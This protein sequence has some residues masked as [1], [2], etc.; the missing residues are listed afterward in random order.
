MELTEFKNRIKSGNSCG[1][2]IFAGEEDYLKKYYLSL[3]REQII[4]DDAFAFFNHTVFEGDD[5]DFASVK[6][7]IK[8]PPMMSEYKLIEWRFADIDS[9]KESEKGALEELFS[10]KEDYPNVCFAILATSAGFDTGTPKRPSKTAARLGSG[11][12]IITL[13]KSTEP[14]LLAWLKRHFEAE[15]IYAPMQALN[16]L[17]FRSG[18]SMDTLNNEV[19]KLCCYAKSQGKSEISVH[20]VEEISASSPESDAFALSNAVIEKNISKAFLAMSDLKMRRV[21]PNAIIA[22]LS[23]TYSELVSVSLLFS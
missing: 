2:Y 20:N 23:R 12:D 19:I 15:G 16:A 3:L 8:S 7:A 17:I 11:F 10:V 18:R 5:I 6:E 4:T 9:L 14:Q 13:N 1:W 22:M 21:E